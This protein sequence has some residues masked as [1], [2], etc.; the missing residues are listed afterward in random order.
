MM[1][2]NGGDASAGLLV[3]MIFAFFKRGNRRSLGGMKKVWKLG[4]LGS[5]SGS[6]CQ[7][8]FDA[9]DAGEL[10]AEV[11][12][13][14]SDQPQAYLLERAK[15]RGIAAEVIDCRGKKSAFP[16]DAQ[17]ETAERLRA[18]GIDFVCL[19]GFMRL[20]KAPLLEAFPQR[21]LN[22]HPSL[23]PAFPGLEAW[24]Q[25]WEAKVPQAGCTV[26]WVDAGMDTGEVIVQK[27]VPVL[28][29][30][31]PESLHARIQV[32]EHQAYPEAL[33]VIFSKLD[34]FSDKNA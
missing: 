10:A 16:E 31:T 7:A 9:I 5:G 32:A 20:V 12:L 34:S 11:V 25:A 18:A 28:S 1:E 14:M 6:N 13:V 23:L 22:I 15:A 24:K 17:R 21:I 8:I 27:A 29:D 26:H 33:N 4:V 3:E 30:D 19:A 2:G